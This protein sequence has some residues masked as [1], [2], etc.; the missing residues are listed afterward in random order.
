MKKEL[1]KKSRFRK[2]HCCFGNV[3]EKAFRLT[4]RDFLIDSEHCTGCVVFGNGVSFE[5]AY[6]SAA[7]VWV[8]GRRSF[9]GARRA[10][11]NAW[12]QDGMNLW[13]REELQRYEVITK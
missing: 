8:G 3:P 2:M 12:A 11:G 6:R 10:R 9:C 13:R 1:R 4:R 5:A 7:G